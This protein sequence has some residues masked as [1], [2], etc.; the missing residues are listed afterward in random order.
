MKLYKKIHIYKKN[1]FDKLG[2]NNRDCYNAIGS[3]ITI[4]VTNIK[5]LMIVMCEKFM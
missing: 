1:I 5:R 2:V 3:R 4:A